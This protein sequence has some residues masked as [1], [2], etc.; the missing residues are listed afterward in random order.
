MMHRVIIITVSDCAVCISFCMFFLKT[1]LQLFAYPVASVDSL[2]V[3]PAC[4]FLIYTGFPL[5]I[6]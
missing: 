6:R 5:N 4:I 1:G 3:P 2:K